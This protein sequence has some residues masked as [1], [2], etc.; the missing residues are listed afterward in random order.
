MLGLRANHVS[1]RGPW[2]SIY[3]GDIV[4]CKRFSHYWS[5]VRVIHRSQ[6]DSIHKD[7]LI[8][9]FDG[10]FENLKTIV[11]QTAKLPVI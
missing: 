6:V 4:T 7:P 5:F 9:S 1:K 3:H 11:E 10:F 8:R 2:I